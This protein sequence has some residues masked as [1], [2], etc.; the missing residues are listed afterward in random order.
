MLST[1]LILCPEDE[2]QNKIAASV[3][4]YGLD[5]LLSSNYRQ[6]RNLL[7]QHDLAAAFCS[8]TLED[9]DYREIL[10]IAKPVP[11][12]VLSRFAAWRPYLAALRAGAFDYIACPPD[13]REVERILSSAVSQ[14]LRLAS[15]DDQDALGSAR[16]KQD[17]PPSR[18]TSETS[19]ATLS[20]AANISRQH[21][22]R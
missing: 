13:S 21:R 5:P 18:S 1:V 16:V 12:I 20:C 9:A 17:S 2:V 10:E 4:K 14:R 19:I 7:E 3:R 15:L 11:V 6:A 22:N 8:D